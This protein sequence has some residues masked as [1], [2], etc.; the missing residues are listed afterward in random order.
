M[1]SYNF[2]IVVCGAGPAGASTSLFLS[3]EGIRHLI[4]DKTSFPRKKVCGDGITPVCLTMLEQVIP[5][6]KKDFAKPEYFK[7]INRFRLYG[8]SGRFADLDP[9]DYIP[10]GKSQLFTVSRFTFD[11][12]LVNHVKQQESAEFWDQTKVLDYEKNKNGITLT[13][14]RNGEPITIHCKM[15]VAADGD[16]SLFKK[17][18]LGTA[19]DRTK[20]VAAI[21]TYY[22]NVKPINDND[23]YE[24]FAFN[25]VLPG[26]F[27][28]FPMADGTYNVGLGITSD[29]IQAKKINLKKLQ[30]QLIAEHPLLADRFKDAE[31]LHAIEGSGLPIM[32]DKH[33]KVSDDRVLLVGDAASVAD[34]ISGE[35]IGPG[36]I[37]GK[38]AALAAM[39]ALKAD[40]FS[41]AFLQK[42]YD[43]K[44]HEK[45]TNDY[46]LRLKLFDWFM[47]RP[48]RI[49]VLLWAAPKLGVIR[50]FFTNSVN[51]RFKWSDLRNPMKWWGIF[52]VSGK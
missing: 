23:Q 12:Y 14:E 13:V 20:M 38:Y 19:I 50:H 26:Y 37:T 25:E 34:P 45:I 8:P 15:V 36:L 31:M 6:V 44:I 5:G 32:M 2:D 41:A 33:P 42:A 24:I 21:R 4:L 43:P 3:K 46:E 7:K 48:W 17:R 18:V 30:N 10:E 11:E 28:I 35:G 16:R 22:K 39:E 47:H 29:V 51:A 40:D 52:G 49:H 27:W 1:E 9:A